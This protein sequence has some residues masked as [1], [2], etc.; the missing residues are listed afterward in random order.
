MNNFKN[1]VFDLGGVLIDLDRE[2]CVRSFARIGFAEAAD[3]L[4]PYRQS[5]VF[6]DL[7]EGKIT[8]EELY[9][10]I[11]PRASQ[12]VTPAMIDRALCDFLVDLPQYKLDLLLRL[13]ERYKVYMLSNTNDIMFRYIVG[14][15]FSSDGHIPEDYFDRLFLSFQMGVVKPDPEIFRMM[16]RQ[17]GFDPADTL[18]IDDGPANIEAAA[19]LGYQTYLAH[20]K[21]D[22]THLFL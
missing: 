12:P 1:V 15:W 7:E 5:G 20:P 4:D 6:L 9:A 17:A 19:R 18:F 14:R 3:M 10:Y 11:R 2:A 13:R 16:S 21:E 22:F 8:P